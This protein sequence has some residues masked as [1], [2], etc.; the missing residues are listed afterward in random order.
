MFNL[1]PERIIAVILI[2]VSAKLYFDHRNKE[3][4]GIYNETNEYKNVSVLKHEVAKQ[5]TTMIV[6]ALIVGLGADK[7]YDANDFFGS[8]LG[9]LVAG[10]TGFFVFYEFIQ[11]HVLTRLPNF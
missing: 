10:V 6:P 8:F 9:Q 5:A 1:T 11:P 2:V 7:W 3:Y 4:T